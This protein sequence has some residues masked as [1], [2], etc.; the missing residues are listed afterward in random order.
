MSR[1]RDY[2]AH[3]SIDFGTVVVNGPVTTCK[4]C[5]RLLAGAAP[6]LCVDCLAPIKARK[7]AARKARK[8]EKRQRAQ[9]I[10]D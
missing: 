3:F 10:A 4:Q 7:H 6:F 8:M 2:T 1:T 5:N 9:A